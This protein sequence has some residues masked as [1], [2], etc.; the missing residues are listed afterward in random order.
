[1][2][3]QIV[4]LGRAIDIIA[5]EVPDQKTLGY[6]LDRIEREVMGGPQRLEKRADKPW[7]N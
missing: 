1:M 4:V 2:A 7:L 3:G 6:I 5:D